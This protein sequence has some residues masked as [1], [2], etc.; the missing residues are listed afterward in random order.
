VDPVPDPLLLRK[1][2]SAGNQTRDLWICS[3]EVWPLDHS[4]GQQF[5]KEYLKMNLRQR[6]LYRAF[7]SLHA[8]RPRMLYLYVH[9]CYVSNLCLHLTKSTDFELLIIFP[10]PCVSFSPLRSNIIDNTLYS[11]F[12]VRSFV[13]WLL[14]RAAS[15]SGYRTLKSKMIVEL[16]ILIQPRHLKGV[17]EKHTRKP[18]IRIVGIPAEISTGHVP[19]ASQKLHLGTLLCK[20][21]TW[22]KT[23]V[24]SVLN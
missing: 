19:N 2:G 17:P 21:D 23:K 5:L 15:N 16:L 12:F 24:V 4:G 6:N 9:A 11:C 10:R 3:Q 20:W 8:S 1:S 13:C 18:S 7:S 22:C 14:S